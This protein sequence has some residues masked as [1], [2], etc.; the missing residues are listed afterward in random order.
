MNDR[1]DLDKALDALAE[2]GI[3]G[4]LTNFAGEK[5]LWEPS[6]RELGKSLC[7][8][9]ISLLEYNSCFFLGTSDPSR[10][11]SEGE[12]IVELLAL[13]ESIGCLN[14]VTCVDGAR[15]I[16]AH[17]D[18]HNP[19]RL[20]VLRR[21]CEIV[22]EG[23]SRRNIRA[24]LMLELVYTTPIHSPEVLA[25]FI[26]GVGSPNVQGHMDLANTL[27]FDLLFD[28]AEFTRQAFKT[29]GRRIHSAHLKDVRA[30]DSYFPGI[31]E[32]LVG[33]G[34]MDYRTYLE[35]LAQMGPAFP[36]VI[37]HMNRLE[38][39]VRS[40]RRIRAIADSLGIPVW[41]E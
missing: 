6:T 29:C 36:V 40:Y 24:R 1:V 21:T 4:C 13:A 9:G 20:D 11:R 5:T 14:V 26:D 17:P 10:C 19:E 30:L 41:S 25:G 31:Q 18:N 33:E 3:R 15:G 37:E 39:I 32:C 35:C 2:A 7:R 12:Q 38:D 28:H 22:A 23:C 16:L 8:A 34:V 27:T